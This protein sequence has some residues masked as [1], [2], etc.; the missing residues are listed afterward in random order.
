MPPALPLGRR[1]ALDMMDR[2]MGRGR[3][4]ARA[5]LTRVRSNAWHIAQAAIAAGVAWWIASGVLDHPQPFFAPVAAVVSLGTSYVQRYHRVVEVAVGVAIG[6]FLGDLFVRM[7]G[8]GAWQI[9]AVV[10]VSMTAALF[11]Y[12]PG[13]LV[14]QAAVQSI[15]VTVLVATPGRSFTRWTDALIGGAV[16]LL[17]AAVI[18]QAPLRR[19]RAAAARAVRTIADI[20]RGTAS[21]AAT[22]DI[23]AAAR[24]LERAREMDPVV[25]ELVEAAEE[26]HS[27]LRSSPFRRRHRDDI[28]AVSDVVASIDRALRSARGLSRRVVNAAYFDRL[29]PASYAVLI[30]DVAGAANLVADA[31]ETGEPPAAA[32]DAMARVAARTARVT[33]TAVLENEMILAQLRTTI[34]ELLQVT[35]MELDDAAGALPVLRDR[36]TPNPEPGAA[37]GDPAA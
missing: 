9:T 25:R 18:P 31:M 24:V 30:E 27:A 11:L 14:T 2:A 12:T 26:G 23:E 28:T 36:I 35:G 10:A 6:V 15:V 22:G 13:L 33:R 32:R 5:R 19:P 37:T 20:L 7:V 3:L 34:V 16:A 8:T 17:A 4:S 29:V 21:A 1:A